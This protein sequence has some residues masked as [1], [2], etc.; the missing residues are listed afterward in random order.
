MVTK[1]VPELAVVFV[2]VDAADAT[3]VLVATVQATSAATAAVRRM[4]FLEDMGQFIVTFAV[5]PTRL[6]DRRSYGIG[7]RISMATVSTPSGMG[8]IVRP[9]S[10]KPNA[11]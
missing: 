5:R 1:L 9:T 4:K 3:G 11:R 2:V 10:S 8:T 6:D 7:R